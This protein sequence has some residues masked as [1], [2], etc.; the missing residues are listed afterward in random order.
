[1]NEWRVGRHQA[2]NIYWGEEFVMVVV[3]E[4][5]AAG[6]RARA[7][8][9]VLNDAEEQ[10]RTEAAQSQDWRDSTYLGGRSR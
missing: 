4:E 2:R 10:T 6:Q 7:L 3:G 5:Q 8:V 1:M 9:A